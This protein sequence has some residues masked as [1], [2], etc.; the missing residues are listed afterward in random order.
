MYRVSSRFLPFAFL[1]NFRVMRPLKMLFTTSK[2]LFNIAFCIYVAGCGDRTGTGGSSN[3][4]TDTAAVTTTADTGPKFTKEGE[5]YFISKTGT[6]TIRK[7]EVE[8]AETDDERSKGLMDRKAMTDEQGMLF[9]FSAPEEQ[10]FWMKNTYISLDIIYVDENKEIVSI[11]KYATPLSEES[12]PS[13]KKAMYVVEVNAGF[14]DKYHVAY[15]DKI[16][17]TKSN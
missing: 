4:T 17:Y 3:T 9:I 7:I 11:Q 8:L 15:G 6:D 16:A 14:C 13:F 5:L 2:W 1:L 10:S 12:L